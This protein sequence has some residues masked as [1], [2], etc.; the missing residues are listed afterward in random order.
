MKP[1]MNVATPLLL[2]VFLSLI[3]G[4]ANNTKSAYPKELQEEM[5]YCPKIYNCTIYANQTNEEH[6]IFYIDSCPKILKDGW[7]FDP[8]TVSLDAFYSFC[9]R[10]KQRNPAC[11][12]LPC[13]YIY[14]VLRIRQ[15]KITGP[16][17]DILSQGIKTDVF[18]VYNRI[19][20]KLVYNTCAPANRYTPSQ[21]EISMEE[22]GDFA[23]LD[24]PSFQ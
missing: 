16:S 5:D 8:D 3:C 15:G 14:C 22:A 7:E 21:R 18:T 1:L 4:C 6:A 20:D 11:K 10:T 24:I 2:T 9:P 19:T 23:K 13:H 12:L 17:G